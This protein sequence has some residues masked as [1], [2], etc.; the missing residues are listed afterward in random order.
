[1]Q[2]HFDQR[3]RPRAVAELAACPLPEAL[4]RG[5]EAPRGARLRERDRAGQRTR[6]VREH[7]QVVVE[8]EHEDLGA[9]ARAALVAGDLAALGVHGEHRA[10]EAHV[11]AAAGAGRG[12]R[13]ARAAYRDARLAVGLDAQRHRA[14]EWLGGE[15]PQR[16]PLALRRLADG[17]EPATDVACVVCAVGGL[18]QRVELDQAA[19][20]RNRHEVAAAEAPD[21]TLH[22]ALL[23]GA[24]RPGL[25]VEGVLA[26]VRAQR[27]ETVA[28]HAVAAAQHAHHG[29]LQVVV[30]DP[31]RHAPETAEGD[32]VALEE[33]LLSFAGEADVDRPPRVRETHHEHRQLGQL[34]VQV[35]A[36]RAEV[37]LGLLA[38]GMD[39]G[40]GPGGWSPPCG[41]TQARAAG[42]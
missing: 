18:E 11:H 24:A 25:A 7:L 23:V 16:G 15:R 2:Q 35:D 28:L 26:V 38:R 8:H 22:A 13:V 30:A 33:R 3:T 14:V 19:H 5:R 40:D 29:R 9:L 32:H 1:M 4:V 36:H 12:D 42:G 31:S 37:D 17:L 6:L 41:W 34:P 20:E 39:S 27:R 10:T 21:L